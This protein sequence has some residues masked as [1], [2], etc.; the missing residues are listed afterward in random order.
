LVF[1]AATTG[2]IL[3][4]IQLEERDLLHFYGD[5]YQAYR[6][7]VSM[8]IPRRPNRGAEQPVKSPG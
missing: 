2:Y 7:Q 8:L 6:N 1:A 4:A 5:R 3:I